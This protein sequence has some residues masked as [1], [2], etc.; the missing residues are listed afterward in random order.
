M[1]RVR[2]VFATCSAHAAGRPDDRQVAGLVGAD[3]QV[4]DDAGVDWSAYDRVVLRSVWDYSHRVEAFL[5]WCETVGEERLRNRPD[6]VAFN[7]DKRYLSE[8]GVPIVPTAFVEPGESLT[9]YAGEIVVKPNISAGARDTGRFGEDA[10][11]DAADLVTRIHDSG[12]IA[13]IQ[14]YLSGVDTQGE[15]A[16][17]FF[18]GLVSHVL[19]KRPVLRTPGVAPLAEVAHAPAAVMLEPDLVSVGQASAQELELAIAAHVEITR[20]FGTPLYARADLVPGTDGTPVLI[21]LELIEPNLHLDLVP[22]AIDRL[23]KAIRSDADR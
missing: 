13:L 21:E 4:W 17:V 16:V 12:R 18:D 14:P 23:A 3:F 2:I 5:E 6:V 19:H 7:A 10:L 11:N 20:R 1:G 22:A 15:T 9:P 8:L